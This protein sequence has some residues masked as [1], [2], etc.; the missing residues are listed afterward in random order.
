MRLEDLRV[1]G[2]VATLRSSSATSG[3]SRYMRHSVYMIYEKRE[4]GFVSCGKA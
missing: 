2:D 3:N 4:L 1:N